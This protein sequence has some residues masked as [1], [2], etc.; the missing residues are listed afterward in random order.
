MLLI[1]ETNSYS[2]SETALLT[3]V[4]YE[5]LLQYWQLL[6]RASFQHSRSG[7][8]AYTALLNPVSPY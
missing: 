1:S 4:P 5:V 6:A 8:P 2:I 7:G 3:A